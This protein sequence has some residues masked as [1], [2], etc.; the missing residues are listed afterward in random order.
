LL[1]VIKS[2]RAEALLDPLVEILRRPRVDAF[3]KETVVVNGQGVRRWLAKEIAQRLGVCAHVRFP[4]PGAWIQDLLV[5]TVGAEASEESPWRPDALQWAVLGALPRLLGKSEFQPLRSYLEHDRSCQ[6]PLSYQL[7]RRIAATFDRYLTYRPRL[8]AGWDRGSVGDDQGWQATL[9]SELVERLGTPHPGRHMQAFLDLVAKGPIRGLPPRLRRVCLFGVSSLPPQHLRVLDRFARS[10]AEVYLFLVTPS[11]RYWGQ[12]RSRREQWRALGEEGDGSVDLT[13]FEDLEEAEE[14]TA[15]HPLLA[16]LGRLGRDFQV[17]LE[18]E[19]TYQA[20]H[21]NLF[22]TPGGE[23]LLATF[24]RDVLELRDRSAAGETPHEISPD[25]SSLLVHACH[26]PMRQVEV[27]QDQLLALFS[28]SPSL[29]PRDVV[30]MS[31]DVET[32]APLVEAV[33]RGASDGRSYL[34]IRVADRARRSGNPL[35]EA[36]L[37]ILNLGG[38]R[39]SASAVLEVLALEPVRRRFELLPEDVSQIADWVRETGI[40]WGL[41]EDD[42][43]DSGQPA[44]RQNTWEWGLDRLLLGY[45]MPGEGR[46]LFA[47]QLPYDEVEGSAALVLGKFSEFCET[48]FRHTRE[49]ASA[50]TAKARSLPEWRQLLWEIVQGVTAVADDQA[51]S[52]K[53]VYDALLK[54]EE[55]AAQAGFD[56]KVSVDVPRSLLEAHFDQAR[57]ATAFLSGAI[58]V[59]GM[60]PMR[61]IGFRVVCLL[62]L[63]DGA[64]PRSAQGVGF[65]AT[66]SKPALGERTVREDDRYQF[67]EALLAARERILIFYSGQSVRDGRTLPPSV[68]VSELLDH[69]GEAFRHPDAAGAA[70]EAARAL[71]L[72]HLV[73]RHPLQP[74]SPRY[75][76]VE[77]DPAHADARLFSFAG[78]YVEGARAVATGASAPTAFFDRPLGPAAPEGH[79]AFALADLVTFTQGPAQDFVRRQLGLYY[80]KEETKITDREPLALSKLEEYGVGSDLLEQA[81]RA[82]QLEA[83]FEGPGRAR[84]LAVLQ[85][86]GRL[87]PGTPGEHVFNAISRKVRALAG[88]ITEI[89]GSAPS[90]EP[91]DVDLDVGDWRLVGCV[92]DVWPAGIVWH[93]YASF[94]AKYLLAAW[95]RHLALCA[96]DPGRQATT[97]LVT[98]GRKDALVKVALQPVGADFALMCLVYFLRLLVDSRVAPLLFFPR[99]SLAYALRL[100]DREDSP[101]ERSEAR[102]RARAKWV[103]GGNVG[104]PPGEGDDE[105]VRRLFG[106]SHPF[107]PE[108]DLHVFMSGDDGRS[109]H[110]LALRIFN[111]VLQLIPNR[112]DLV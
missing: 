111:P 88:A 112:K 52:R 8:V 103:T 58:T 32:F 92:G 110:D 31:P 85:A 37:Q 41:D 46:E 78:S 47:G 77:A 19:V 104:A 9:W 86:S 55:D 98:R 51:E 18:R 83:F 66:A 53:E 61:S 33:F 3:E 87:P 35:A 81:L 108:A 74:F 79:E 59:C 20:P 97:H 109:F 107:D 24:Q 71:L 12:I 99:S 64:F 60:V 101:Y 90:L 1:H 95:V 94:K 56:R 11:D 13:A 91:A 44:L 43:R 54:I 27:L 76:R 73:L 80:P 6:G 14:A 25:D 34:P 29:Q 40:R 21:E 102:R 45:A 28:E 70:P 49:L 89:R 23:S 50:S 106:D 36:L 67:L 5:E 48:F 57:P 84:S 82:P 4:F 10:G 69:L 42:R 2:N 72:R 16:S 22:V 68:V 63:D 15:G 93:S 105:S 75:F 100:F 17:L 38:R 26:S 96:T 30:I 62:G 39:I 65:D 7:A